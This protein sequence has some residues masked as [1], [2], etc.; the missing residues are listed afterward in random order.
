MRACTQ[1]CEKYYD[2]TINAYVYTELDEPPQF[3]GGSSEIIRFLAKNFKYP[4]QEE[5]QASFVVEIILDK[6]GSIK[7]QKI[8]SKDSSEL[9]TEAEISLLNTV[10]KMP[11]WKPGKCKGKNVISRVYLPVKI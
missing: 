10:R 4:E 11:R 2:S 9:L 6:D 1:D 5:L 3:H 7:S 8:K